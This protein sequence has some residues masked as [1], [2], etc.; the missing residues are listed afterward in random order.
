MRVVMFGHQ[1]W[2]H[3]T[4]QGAA[5][6][7]ARG[8]PGGDPSEERPR[9]REDLGR[10]RGRT[11]LAARC[12]GAAAEPA[13]RP[14]VTAGREG[15]AGGHHRGQ[16]LADVAAPEIYDLPPHG[17]LNVHDSL[18]PKY[19]GFLPHHLGADQRRAG[20]GRDGA[21][22]DGG[23]GR[24]ATSLSSGRCR[25]SPRTPRRTF[26]RHR[27]SDHAD[28]ARGTGPDRV[29]AGGVDAAGPVAGV[30]LPQARRLRTAGST[31]RGRRRNWSGC[32]RAQSDPYPNAF[33]SYKGERV[34]VLEASVSEGFY[35]ET[36]GRVFI[37]EKDGI[38]IVAAGGRANRAAARPRHREGPPGRRDRT[39]GDGLL[40]H[41]GRLSRLTRPGI[42]AGRFKRLGAAKPD[43]AACVF[44]R[45]LRQ[46]AC[47]VAEVRTVRRRGTFASARH[48]SMRA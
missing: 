41:D 2:G 27:R 43:G 15:R 26:L 7:I 1:T 42:G 3:R 35:G 8:R 38:V 4:L 20:G 32:V 10:Q 40:P 44:Q 12:A 30:L 24:A 47:Q 34:R 5:G 29:E 33:T 25:C 28:R 16:Q 37:R 46:C 17:T 36:P 11:G 22:D 6:V 19:A 14:G 48:D 45:R 18:L 23:P 39:R 31:G 9:V 21:P 13:D